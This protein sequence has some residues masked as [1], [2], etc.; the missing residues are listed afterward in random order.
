MYFDRS[1][2][3]QLTPEY[4]LGLSPERRAAL[5]E[6]LRKDLMEAQDRLNR[7]PTNS[8]CP[9]S[10]KAPWDRSFNPDEGETEPKKEEPEDKEEP[11]KNDGKTEGQP[12]PSTEKKES[13][14]DKKKKSGKQKGAP[15]FGRTQKLLVTHQ[16]IHRP[17]CCKG[18]NCELRWDLP[19]KAT[20]GHYTIDLTLPKSGTIGLQGINTKHV[21]GSIMC[22]CGFETTT[23]PHRVPGE[24]GWI[25]DVGEWRLIGP[26]LLA[27]LV[28]LKLRMHMT[29]SK[30]G[31]FLSLWLGIK[32]SDGCIN[33]ALREAGRISSHFEPEIIAALK[34]SGL[35]HMD[36]TPWKEHKVTRWFWVAIG[37]HVVYYTI[38]P[39]TI[40]VARTILEGFKG[41]LMTDGLSVYRWYQNR[42]RCWTHLDRKAVALEESWDKEVA[43]FGAYVV[44][45]FESFR[46]SIYKMRKMDPSQRESEQKV[47]E[48]IRLDFIYECFKRNDSQHE[49]TRAFVVEILNDKDV[50]FRQLKEPEFPLTNNVSERALRNMVILRKMCQGSKTAEGSKSIT[51]LAS[52]IDTLRLRKQEVWSFLAEAFSKYRS[53]QSPPSM[54]S[55]A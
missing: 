25:V 54:P 50:I 35:L 41:T 6:Q 30:S 4:V 33:K 2:L 39:R 29:L 38:G 46:Q 43:S 27:F 42:L 26:M 20:G 21:Y 48:E 32:L 28:F 8:S 34:A 55:P 51:S 5:V 37:D 3:Q 14:D 10:S 16:V 31:E 24:S 18:C 12:D 23:S 44:K 19:F 7:N 15:G 52:V 45:T 1:D 9:P 11:P 53:G 22:A 13:S 47:S 40:E 49:A 36:E 17:E